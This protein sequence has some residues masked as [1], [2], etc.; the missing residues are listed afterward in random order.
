MILTRQIFP[1]IIQDGDDR[2]FLDSHVIYPCR[3]VWNFVAAHGKSAGDTGHIKD[4]ASVR[5]PKQII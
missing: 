4:H 5:F 2:G 1:L 3:K